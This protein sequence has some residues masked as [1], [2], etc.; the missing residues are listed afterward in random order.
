[1]HAQLCLTLCDLMNCSP[2][3]SLVH[4]IFQA[5]ILEWIS[6][7]PSRGIFPTQGS[8][9]GLLCLLHWQVDSL[10]LILGQGVGLFLEVVCVCLVTQSCL[11]LC[12][13]MDC[14]HQAPLSMG[15]LQARLLEWVAM[16]S[17]RG[18]C[19]HRVTG[20][21]LMT[22]KLRKQQFSLALQKPL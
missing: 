20:K 5:R 13:P 3:G 19:E 12:D 6:I 2:S 17:S 15:I 8:N 4:G 16:P 11:I 14:S 18:P 22:F 9:L 1:M 21:L 7:S 10:P